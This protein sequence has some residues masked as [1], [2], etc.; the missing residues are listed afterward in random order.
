MAKLVVVVTLLQNK[1]QKLRKYIF[2]IIGV[3]QNQGARIGFPLKP[4]INSVLRGDINK[5]GGVRNFEIPPPHKSNQK[6]DKI[7][8]F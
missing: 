2:S 8:Y 4:Q 7:K 5:N 6:T 3:F 1:N